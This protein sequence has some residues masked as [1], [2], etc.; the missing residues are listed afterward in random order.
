MLTST[1]A[2]ATSPSLRSTML[3]GASLPTTIA[4]G[5]VVSAARTGV[6]AL[7]TDV[8]PKLDGAG[9]GTAACV[10]F[11]SSGSGRVESSTVGAS[12][13]PVAIGEADC[14]ASGLAPL[15]RD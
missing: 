2:A 3:Y 14:D 13:T 11:V 7:P 15:R 4:R 5:P 8:S 9:E 12:A 1:S 6:C 10:D